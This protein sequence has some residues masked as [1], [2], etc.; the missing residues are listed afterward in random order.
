MLKA[1][2]G[3]RPVR[4]ALA[5][6]VVAICFAAGQ[7]EASSIACFA[8]ADA[9]AAQFRR[10]QQD[11][12]VAA[13]SCG[14]VQAQRDSLAARYNQ[15]VGKF[16]ATLRDNAR[17]LLAHFSRHGGASGFDRWMTRLANAAAVEAATDPSYCQRAWVDLDRAL[18]LSPETVADFA[19]AT[20]TSNELV[21]VCGERRAAVQGA[22]LGMADAPRPVVGE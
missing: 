6:S 19:V 11:F 2:A 12:T 9:K 15:F 4:R 21:P 3:K 1:E 17:T 7:A 13:L 22:T 20:A 10:M 14:S 8:P 16:E 18:T 5:V